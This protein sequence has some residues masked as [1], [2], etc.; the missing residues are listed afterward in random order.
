MNPSLTLKTPAFDSQYYDAIVIEKM[1]RPMRRT[2]PMLVADN[3]VD[4]VIH[5]KLGQAKGDLLN[6]LMQVPELQAYQ[7]D[8]L[9]SANAMIQYA[10]T[11][12][13]DEFDAS[14]KRI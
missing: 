12:Y 11:T 13:G 4:V 10:E 14:K 6:V 7:Q 1:I 2:V 3:E 8:V 5:T 9:Q